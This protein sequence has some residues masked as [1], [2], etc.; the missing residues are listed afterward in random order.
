MEYIFSGYRRIM[1]LL[2]MGVLILACG[3]AR[4]NTAAT[5]ATEV[6]V[7]ESTSTP[8]S[9]PTDEPTATATTPAT[10]TP[11]PLPQSMVLL[12][13]NMRQG[14]SI[15]YAV[16][17]VVTAKT[18]VE[19]LAVREEAGQHWYRVRAD[20]DEGWM[21]ASVLSVEKSV[22]VAVPVDAEAL[23]PPPTPTLKPVA[24]VKPTAAPNPGFVAPSTGVRIGAICRDGTRSSA[25][26]RG[27]C[28]HH[29]GVARW[30][31]Q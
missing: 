13:A 12:D 23:A 22:A 28:S 18:R 9:T 6:P 8:Q 30:L 19:L 3:Q 15:R 20:G 26:G 17:R 27:A 7:S 29:G 16:V 1:V 10:A 5:I 24:V 31:T 14:P 21:S 25:T 4:P 11:A 2:C